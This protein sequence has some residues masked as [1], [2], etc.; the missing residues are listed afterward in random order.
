VWLLVR[1]NVKNIRLNNFLHM[2]LAAQ[3]CNLLCFV[4]LSLFMAENSLAYWL[5]A[6]TDLALSQLLLLIVAPWFF[7]LEKNLMRALNLDLQLP[8][9]AQRP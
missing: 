6:L 8:T 2:T 1:A 3:L 4:G 7:A 5:R 9:N